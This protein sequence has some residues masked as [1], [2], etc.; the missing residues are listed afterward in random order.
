MENVLEE[1]QG[2]YNKNK[3]FISLVCWKDA[4]NI[5]LFVYKKILP[6]L[7][8]EER[9]NLDIQLRKTSCSSTANIA[10]GYGRFHF[11]E[12]LQFYRISKGSTYET[13]DH[14]ISC[15]D[16]GYIS[17]ELYNEG[18]ELIEKAKISINGYI[19][20]VKKQKKGLR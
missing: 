17:I 5:K 2:T 9:F 19:H 20:Y 18:K 4:R 14:L 8:K 13:K 7:P 15:Y 11:Q 10:E 3:D 1:P 6:K 16:L 12:G